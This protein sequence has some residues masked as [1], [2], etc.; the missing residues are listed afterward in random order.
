MIA[1]Y[2]LSSAN[3]QNRQCEKERRLYRSLTVFDVN[4][5]HCQYVK[6]SPS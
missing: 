6:H 4:V 2:L 5:A 3:D 1:T